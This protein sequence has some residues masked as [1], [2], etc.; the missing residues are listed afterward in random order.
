MP[1]SMCVCE[2]SEQKKDTRSPHVQYCPTY[3]ALTTC[4]T[5][6]LQTENVRFYPPLDHICVLG[7][8]PVE[9][10]ISK[11]PT[12]IASTPSYGQKC[13][14]AAFNC[15]RCAGNGKE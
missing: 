7:A 1:G 14:Q 3:I 15:N 2:V 11:L 9:Q 12:F 13:C 8:R 4:P 10:R 5:H 6:A